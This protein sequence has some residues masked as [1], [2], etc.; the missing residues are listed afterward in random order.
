[1]KLL[2]T[3]RS[4][5]T[6]ACTS[7]SA[8]ASVSDVVSFAS[9]IGNTVTAHWLREHQATVQI[10]D[11][12]WYMPAAKR[13]CFDEHMA[14]RIPSARFFD[15]DAIADKSTDLPHMLPSDAT[16][17]AA[18]AN[19]GITKRK[20]IIVYDTSGL[21]AAARVWW[22]FK[23]FGAEQ[24]AVL[25]GGL[26]AWLAAEYPIESGTPTPATPV[27][28]EDWRLDRDLVVDYDFVRKVSLARGGDRACALELSSSNGMSKY[29]HK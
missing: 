26:P 29:T 11:G 8:M 6:A 1:M 24:V 19:M 28:H 10:I 9:R 2:Q 7:A 12:S 5:H 18:V 4:M 22:T 13:N 21:F 23:A 3:C 25:D 14:A 27:P 20:P 16:F 17:T 15:I